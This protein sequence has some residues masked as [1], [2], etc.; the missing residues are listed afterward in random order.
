VLSLCQ[1]DADAGRSSTRRPAVV[2]C[3]RLEARPTRRS[4]APRSGALASAIFAGPT[5]VAT[6]V[7]RRVAPVLDER[8]GLAWASVGCVFLL[9]V[10]WGPTHALRT[11]WGILLLGALIAIGVVGLRHQTQREFPTVPA[12]PGGTPLSPARALSGTGD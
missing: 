3:E 10:L 11:W 8:P 1:G 9:L 7:R 6:S 5:S 2:V 4:L 12:P